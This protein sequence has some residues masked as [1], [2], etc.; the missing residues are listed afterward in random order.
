M[1]YTILIIV[2]FIAVTLNAQNLTINTTKTVNWNKNY[3]N[4]CSSPQSGLAID[5]DGN[6]IIVGGFDGIDVN[7]GTNDTISSENNTNIFIAK[8]DGSNNLIFLKNIGGRLA[9]SSIYADGYANDYASDVK[10]DNDNNI[11]VLAT[12][13]VGTSDTVDLDPEHSETNSIITN[14]S[15]G[16][17]TILQNVFII[18]YSP[19]GKMLWYR[20]IQDESTDG[21]YNLFIDNN[22]DV[23]ATG[24][25]GGMGN[26]DFDPYHEYEDNHDSILN[27]SFEM[28]FVTHYNSNGDFI[29]V[30]S[31][32]GGY[33]LNLDVYVASS[34]NMY[35]TGSFSAHKTTNSEGLSLFENSDTSIYITSQ[36]YYE[37]NAQNTDIFI[38]KC[39][40]LGNIDWVKTISSTTSNSVSKIALYGDENVCVSGRFSGSDV[41][42]DTDNV[43]LYDTKTSASNG[44]GFIATYDTDGNLRMLKTIEGESRTRIQ[45]FDVT[46]NGVMVVG[47]NLKGDIALDDI[48]FSSTVSNPFIA[49]ID[50]AGNWSDAQRIDDS[51]Y[52][53]IANIEIAPDNSI[54]FIGFNAN[55]TDGYLDV[56]NLFWGNVES[57]LFDTLVPDKNQ[58]YITLTDTVCDS[59]TSPG[60]KTFDTSGVYT[61]TVTGLTVDTIYT[62]NLTVS[63]LDAEISMDGVVLTA[64]LPNATYQWINCMTTTPIEGATNQTFSATDNG[65][66]AVII[67]NSICIDTSNC[68]TI[69]STGIGNIVDSEGLEIFPNPSSDI[70]YIKSCLEIK[71]LNLFDINGKLVLCQSD[72]KQI[73]IKELPKGIYVLKATTISGINY[74][75][76]VVKK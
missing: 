72:S 73:D 52:A 63:N 49:V 24:V 38:L 41:D 47:G 29:D 70:L 28:G 16:W 15:N 45:C 46:E 75:E 17:W 57:K 62:I 56:Q 32:G 61:D 14:S 67:D 36:G 37:L 23:W 74:T 10:V 35:L 50:T 60:G 68:I 48:S 6:K 71:Q 5:S 11:Y 26:V 9:E 18:K 19:E 12:I 53:S 31:I 30:K 51:T 42:F 64:I 2:S 69:A 43:L 33:F 66:Y 54:R 25:I 3:I 1:K 39:N 40:A 22:N 34:G 8:Y 55:I 4:T 21:S 58:I 65:D 44:S 20:E 59:Y 7:F 13:D 76:T 27:S